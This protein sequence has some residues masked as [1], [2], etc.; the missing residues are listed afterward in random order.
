MIGRGSYSL[1]S[2][3]DAAATLEGPA[4]DWLIRGDSASVF[5]DDFTD[6][7]WAVIRCFFSALSE[8]VVEELSLSTEA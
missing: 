5:S 2:D 4:S 7:N 6:T 3:S 1:F 8:E